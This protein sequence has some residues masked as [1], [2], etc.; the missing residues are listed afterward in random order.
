MTMLVIAFCTVALVASYIPAPK[1]SGHVS[2]SS[3]DVMSRLI[4]H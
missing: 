2:E 4:S 3:E 1:D